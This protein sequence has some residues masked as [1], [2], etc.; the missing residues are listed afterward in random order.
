MKHLCR[1]ITDIKWE[2]LYFS[3]ENIIYNRSKTIACTVRCR[4]SFDASCKEKQARRNKK[5]KKK[6]KKQD[7]LR[8][9]F[10]V[11]GR[12]R[13]IYG[14]IYQKKKRI[15]KDATMCTCTY[16]VY[17][18]VCYECMPYWLD[19][20]RVGTRYRD[21]YCIPTVSFCNK[22]RKMKSCRT[23]KRRYSHIFYR[24]PFFFIF[25]IFPVFL[26]S[27]QLLL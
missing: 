16:Y 8:R 5:K 25:S 21:L 26:R 27:L 11:Y 22:D 20:C 1:R 10:A 14:C 17:A 12:N 7:I 15:G 3:P 19:T 18:L 9:R 24:R 13:L 2:Y 6:V 4:S 23:S